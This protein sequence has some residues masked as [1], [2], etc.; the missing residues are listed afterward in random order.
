MVRNG[1]R[2]D[3][4]QM[5]NNIK[6]RAAAKKGRLVISLAEDRSCVP[7]IM[8]IYN[9]EDDDHLEKKSIIATQAA[10]NSQNRR[11]IRRQ[12]MS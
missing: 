8:I 1:I 4:D 12:W 10:K 2:T 11:I 6:M 9:N 5:H 7:F 3:E